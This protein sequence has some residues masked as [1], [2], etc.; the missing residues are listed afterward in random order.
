MGE[1]TLQDLT[2]T[3]VPK[4]SQ[5]TIPT[6]APKT[7]SPAVAPK[8]Q[9]PTVASNTQAASTPKKKNHRYKNKWTTNNYCE[10]CGE[11]DH[12]MK[13]CS[14]FGT[15]EKKRKRLAEIRG[16]QDCADELVKGKPHSCKQQQC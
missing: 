15:P 11:N 2:M 1:Q 7:Q 16:C 8:T 3:A 6:V 14:S 9:S 10:L 4:V 12:K 5:A 13:I